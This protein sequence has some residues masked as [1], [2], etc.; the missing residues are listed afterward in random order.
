MD[1]P[2]PTIYLLVGSSTFFTIHLPSPTSQPHFCL[3]KKAASSN[4]TIMYECHIM[5]SQQSDS[6]DSRDS[7]KQHP[8]TKNRVMLRALVYVAK[9]KIMKY[10]YIIGV[11]LCH[12][13]CHHHSSK[14]EYS[15]WTSFIPWRL[16]RGVMLVAPLRL[17]AAMI[18]L[19]KL[20]SNSNMSFQCYEE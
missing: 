15:S 3:L 13:L 5:C 11:Q 16:L 1:R 19:C 10:Q 2:K 14:H 18:C 7:C 4:R 6:S 9:N 8:K 20:T 12:L 17:M